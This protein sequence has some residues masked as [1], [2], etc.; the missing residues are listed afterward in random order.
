MKKLFEKFAS[1]RTGVKISL[2]L[3]AI[4]LVAG[5]AY[6][7]ITVSSAL[8]QKHVGQ[9]ATA[10]VP[11]ETEQEQKKPGKKSE[12]FWSDFVDSVTGDK[13]EKTDTDTAENTSKKENTSQK[14]DTPPK[15]T[16]GGTGNTPTEPVKYKVQ[17]VVNGGGS[18][19]TLRVAPGTKIS[20]L[21]TPNRDEHVFLGWYYDA[22]LTNMV[23]D[24]DTVNADTTLYAS[25]LEKT[26]LESLERVNFA[27]AED[28][29][30]DFSLR[31]TTSEAMTAQQVADADR[32]S[33]V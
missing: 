30:T 26:P 27:S 18:L 1:L 19:D 6:L 24:N 4:L 29:G 14:E 3:A 20:S 17:F 11:A 31:I 15:E 7:G 23:Q 25:W 9:T 16:E 13:N 2:A 33:V 22:G 8:F 12:S 10:A 21:P 28:V 32:K 5:S